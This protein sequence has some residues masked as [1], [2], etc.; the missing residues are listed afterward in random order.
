MLYFALT[1]LL[2][3]YTPC[4]GQKTCS[5][6]SFT[7][8]RTNSNA[9]KDLDDKA[10][11]NVQVFPFASEDGTP[12]AAAYTQNLKRQMNDRHITVSLSW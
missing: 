3:S 10:E 11:T 1:I 9:D 6:T 7:M 8:S 4:A 12:P 5:P 2:K